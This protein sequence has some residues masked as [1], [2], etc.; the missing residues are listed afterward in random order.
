MIYMVFGGVAQLGERLNGI[1][2]AKGSSPSVSTKILSADR[3]KP[4]YN[5]EKRR[6]TVQTV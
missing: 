4:A 1:Q 6:M 2:K 5:K 3:P